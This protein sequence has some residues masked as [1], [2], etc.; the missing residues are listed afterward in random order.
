MKKQ[1]KQFRELL[2]LTPVALMLLAST[3]AYSQDKEPTHQRAPSIIQIGDGDPEISI[4]TQDDKEP[5]PYTT[6]SP[7]EREI[8]EA[9]A[10]K[11]GREIDWDLI[12][13]NNTESISGENEGDNESLVTDVETVVTETEVESD[14]E[15]IIT[16]V[17]T[18]VETVV[19]E[20]EVDT[21]TIESLKKK[22][23]EK[24]QELEV[25][26]A[27]ISESPVNTSEEVE[28]LNQIILSAEKEIST[29]ASKVSDMKVEAEFAALDI[30]SLELQVGVV[31]I[32]LEEIK[33][34]LAKKEVEIAELKA[35]KTALEEEKVALLEETKKLKEE[36]SELETITCKQENRLAKLEEQVSASSSAPDMMAILM[37]QQQQMMMSMTMM[38]NSGFPMTQAP[39]LSNGNDNLNMMMMMQ[40]MQQEMRMSNFQNGIYG[41]LGA[42]NSMQ[43]TYQ[44]TGDYFNG[45]QYSTMNQGQPFGQ[46]AQLQNPMMNNQ[47]MVMQPFNYNMNRTLSSGSNI[48]PVDNGTIETEGTVTNPD[49]SEDEVEDAN[50]AGMTV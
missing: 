9:E 2:M 27:S 8:L 21:E 33:A 32:E 48:A 45:G 39:S 23:A 26:R 15:S 50:D 4:N 25:L 47:A 43:P 46:Q 30:E 1:T 12:A 3:S 36:K 29:L 18:E 14:P 38:M 6:V 19:A 28:K 16:E 7:A 35:E 10:K 34:L 31:E 40:S 41:M 24:T 11:E 37:M 20:T 44:I 17:E 5:N 22:L 42:M 49:L 13:R